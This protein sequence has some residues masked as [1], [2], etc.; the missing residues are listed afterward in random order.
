MP[1]VGVPAFKAIGYGLCGDVSKLP[2]LAMRGGL[3]L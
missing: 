2:V 1:R 3:G